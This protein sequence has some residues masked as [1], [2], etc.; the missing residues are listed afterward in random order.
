MSIPITLIDLLPSAAVE[1]G[2]VF[3]GSLN[4]NLSADGLKNLKKAVKRRQDWQAV[5]SSEHVAC[6]PFAQWLA[7]KNHIPLQSYAQLAEMHFGQWEGQAPADIMEQNPTVLARWWRNPACLIPPEG[8]S[9]ASFQARI[10]PVWEQ[11]VTANQG[12]RIAL[13]A[14]PGVIRLI[15]MQVLGMPSRNFFSL[16]VEPGTIAR[17]QVM[18]DEAGMWSSLVAYGCHV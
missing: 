1:A 5:V 4:S 11:I 17:I 2:E 7:E 14:Q 3:C 13:V 16:A 10:L 9:F 18:H 15:I 8:E 6:L 12:K